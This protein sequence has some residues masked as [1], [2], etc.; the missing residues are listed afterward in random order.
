[1]I[2]IGSVPALQQSRTRPF[3]QKPP[4]LLNPGGRVFL[5]GFGGS[6]KSFVLDFLDTWVAGGLGLGGLGGLGLGVGLGLPQ[7]PQSPCEFVSVG[8]VWTPISSCLFCL[9]V[10]F[11]LHVNQHLLFP[12]VRPIVYDRV[13]YYDP[14]TLSHLSTKSNKHSRRENTAS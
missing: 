4:K 2:D 11:L 5:Q 12:T 13:L 1:V 14:S 10:S 7:S 6:G 8:H 9:L 3:P